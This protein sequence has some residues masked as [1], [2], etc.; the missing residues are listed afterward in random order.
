MRVKTPDYYKDF[1]CIA[2]ECTDSCCAGWEVD[3]D[4]K[5]QEYYVTVEG[6]FGKRLKDSTIIDE[7]GIRFQLTENKRCCFLNDCNLC[8]L[9]TALGEEHLC[10]TCTDFPRFSEEFGDLREK[11]ISLSCPTAAGL[12]L[13]HPKPL[14]FVEQ[15]EDE[16]VALNDIDYDLY[17]QL[18]AARKQSI[19][20]M[21]NRDKDI[22]WR[23][24]AVLLMANDIQK[25]IFKGKYKKIAKVREIYADEKKIDK[26]ILKMGK[27]A[28]KHVDGVENFKEII[29]IYKGFEGINPV[30]PGKL[31]NAKK[32]AEECPNSDGDYQTYFKSN[33]IAYE[34]MMVYFIYRYYLKTVYDYDLIAKVKFGI[35]G[36]LVIRGV[37]KAE[38]KYEKE[39]KVSLQ[40]LI[41]NAHLYS[42]EIE[43]SDD[44]MQQME[45]LAHEDLHFHL[46]ALLASLL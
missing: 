17:M 20:I 26:M 40:D 10:D 24:M 42:K 45:R 12:I 14:T 33:A 6:D 44:N 1:K 28:L 39:G 19:S 16:M 36:V 7:E 4:E 27:K 43:H 38:W 2:G 15:E 18:V 8:D 41:W 37:D 32:A 31:E 46:E 30:W 35:A 22:V 23:L 13:D 34:Q 11:G 5:A 9:Y 3:V 29:D 25:Y 21:Q